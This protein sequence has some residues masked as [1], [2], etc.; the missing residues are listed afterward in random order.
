MDLEETRKQYSWNGPYAE[1]ELKTLE[2]LYYKNITA[3]TSG[4]LY[5]LLKR[6]LERKKQNYRKVWELNMSLIKRGNWAVK[7]E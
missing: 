3:A 1:E 2:R 4:T 7:R 6:S 5:M